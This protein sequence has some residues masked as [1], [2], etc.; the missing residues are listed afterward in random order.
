MQ[1]MN[2]IEAYTETRQDPQELVERY[3]RRVQA[4]ARL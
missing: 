3:K 2:K 4:E 1:E